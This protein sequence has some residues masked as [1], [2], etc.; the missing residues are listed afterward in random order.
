MLNPPLPRTWLLVVF[1]SFPFSPS[2][3]QYTPSPDLLVQLASV[4]NLWRINIST[5][6]CTSLLQS[7]TTLRKPQDP[8][9][10]V[11]YPTTRVCTMEVC[12]AIP[13]N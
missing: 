13:R 6:F 11:A 7:C 9:L 12:P 10:Q 1:F 2:F 8:R 5:H 3:E 4:K